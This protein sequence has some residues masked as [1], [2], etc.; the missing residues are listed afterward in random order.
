MFACKYQVNVVT[1]PLKLLYFGY[2]Q[3]KGIHSIPDALRTLGF[4]A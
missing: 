2:K 3:M 1:A 4:E